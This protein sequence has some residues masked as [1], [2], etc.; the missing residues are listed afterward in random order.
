M[1]T[2]Y[3]SINGSNWINVTGY[4][5]KAK[6]SR[7]VELTKNRLTMEFNPVI[8]SYY[9]FGNRLYLK[10]EDNSNVIFTAITSKYLADLKKV[11]TFRVEGL[12]ASMDFFAGQ[13]AFYETNKTATEIVISLAEKFSGKE[14][15]INAAKTSEGGYIY[16]T[17]QNISSFYGT[18]KRFYDYLL[19]VSQAEY[20]GVNKEFIF[21]I[22]SENNLHWEPL[23]DTSTFLSKEDTISA[24]PFFSPAAKFNHIVINCGTDLNGDRILA[25]YTDMSG[26]KRLGGR[27]VTR[28]FDETQIAEDVKKN[29]PGYTNEQVIEATKEAGRNKAKAYIKK[30]GMMKKGLQ[31]LLPYT[32]SYSVGSKI[33]TDI[34]LSS[35]YLWKVVTVEHEFGT[36]S[37]LT[38]LVLEEVV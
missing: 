9:D 14:N 32:T 37:N 3:I 18:N 2:F 36:R 23:S 26:Y 29:N 31:V 34:D 7:N 5:L 24:R 16:E 17:T 21:Y 19:D 20:T 15:P 10:V 6:I 12:D 28:Y 4:V 27:L 35:K 11:D 13:Q 1:V 25:I 8:K 22:D 38:R 30:F 33:K